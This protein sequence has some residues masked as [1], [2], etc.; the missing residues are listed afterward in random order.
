VI[1]AEPALGVYLTPEQFDQALEAVADFVDLKSPYTLG[2]ARA[3]AAL[4]A[5][6]GEH[7]GIA[8][9]GVVSLRR[10]AL[11][12]G[13]GRLGVS[14]AIWDKPGPLGVGEWERVRMQPYITERMLQQSDALAPLGRIAVQYR[15]RMDGSGYPRGLP[16]N[17][18]TAPARLFGAAD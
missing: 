13:L 9:V 11:V 5:A 8:G 7:L 14:N 16:G 4:A 15:E 10:A 17:S 3:V 12:H 2:H 1:G 18:I 6:A